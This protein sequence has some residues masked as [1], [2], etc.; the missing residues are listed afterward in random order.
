MIEDRYIG[1]IRTTSLKKLTKLIHPSK[2]WYVKGK[3]EVKEADANKF[4]ISQ[5]Y[6]PY[7]VAYSNRSRTIELEFDRQK[8]NVFLGEA[9]TIA[10]DKIVNDLNMQR[11]CDMPVE[12]LVMYVKDKKLGELAGTEEEEFFA[13]F[14]NVTSQSSD[15]S[16]V[17]KINMDLRAAGLKYQNRILDLKELQTTN[18]YQYNSSTLPL[19]RELIKMFL[20]NVDVKRLDDMPLVAGRV[21]TL[22]NGK[23][24]EIKEVENIGK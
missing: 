15:T 22:K 21:E 6:E 10:I 12:Q 4:K 23:N 20:R 17:R 8:H 24:W 2:V 13:I 14:R 9:V 11:A 1:Y 7:L 5:P 18:Q 16:L 19:N 3:F